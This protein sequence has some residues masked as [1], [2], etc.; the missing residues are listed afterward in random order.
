[1]IS[2]ERL[3]IHSGARAGRD[4]TPGIA[5]GYSVSGS[6]LLAQLV[7]HFHGKEGVVGSS[8]TEGL[9]KRPLSGRFAFRA[10]SASDL[11][12]RF[13]GAAPWNGS[14]AGGKSLQTGIFSSSPV[15]NREGVTE[16]AAPALGAVPVTAGGLH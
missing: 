11:V 3:F 13:W 15:L 12:G 10:G 5:H 9:S 2:P 6:A 1:M 8:P 16:Q 7:E 14:T 4:S